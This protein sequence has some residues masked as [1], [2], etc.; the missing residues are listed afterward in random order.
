M[1]RTTTEKDLQSALDAKGQEVKDEILNLF[2]DWVVARSDSRDKLQASTVK[3]YRTRIRRIG[4]W[5]GG[6]KVR[7]V[8]ASED[9]MARFLTSLGTDK[10][11]QRYLDLVDNLQVFA[12]ARQHAGMAKENWPPANRSAQKLRY[13]D[14]IGPTL[15]RHNERTPRTLSFGERHNFIAW[16]QSEMY[17]GDWIPLR[18]RALCALMLGAGLK[19]IEAFGVQLDDLE[20]ENLIEAK[21]Y[22]PY[23]IR[24]PKNSKDAP[25][26]TLVDD[27]AKA[28]IA[29]WVQAGF[30]F[31]V[32]RNDC[33]LLFPSAEKDRTPL[34]NS[35]FN[36]Q[37]QDILS[38]RCTNTNYSPHDL[39]N[40]WLVYHLKTIGK[41]RLAKDRADAAE[42][43]LRL[44]AGLADEDALAPFKQVIFEIPD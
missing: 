16:C 29:D 18:N 28:C 1:R 39:R 35:G 34:E 4:D 11:R 10:N 36:R 27:W 7:L 31:G 3:N 5:F 22:R 41:K 13:S 44:C 8:Q 26:E 24:L 23:K 14:K 30:R 6:A 21:R 33:D 2:E 19:P 42:E 40:T 15:R 17:D 9:S 25:H 12:H 32:I 43:R 20:Y 37:F 38:A